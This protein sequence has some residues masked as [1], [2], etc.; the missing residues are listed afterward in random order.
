MTTLVL[1]RIRV[2]SN[3]VAFML[4]VAEC[5]ERKRKISR[6]VF[7]VLHERRQGKFHFLVLQWWQRNV[8]KHVQHVCSTCKFGFF[9]CSLPIERFHMTS[10]R[11]YGCSKTCSKTRKR[12]PCLAML[13][14][15]ENLLGVERLFLCSE[16]FFCSN[17]LAWML[18][19][20]VKT[21]YWFFD[22]LV[23]TPVVVAE[24]PSVH[25]R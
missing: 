21:F 5:L 16:A 12:P 14:Y 22:V 19:T 6:R 3:C 20:C 1:K 15:Q 4:N 23:D 7:T 10:R 9:F 11:L 13:V 24:G 18:I 17:K 8:L 25:L 2:Y